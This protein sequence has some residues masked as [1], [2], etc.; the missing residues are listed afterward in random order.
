M[1][2][3][4]IT[5]WKTGLDKVELNRLLRQHAGLKLHEA[6][7]AVDELLEGQTV[8]VECSDPASASSLCRAARAIGAVCSVDV[9][10]RTN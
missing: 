1:A 3:L 6:K 4:A 9:V 10:V 5:G 7:Q 2:R 8:T